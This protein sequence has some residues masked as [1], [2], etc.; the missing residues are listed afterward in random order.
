MTSTKCKYNIYFSSVKKQ[1]YENNSSFDQK[2]QKSSVNFF[3]ALSQS[4]L[5]LLGFCNVQ[6][7]FKLHKTS[8]WNGFD[9]SA[10]YEIIGRFSKI[11][12]FFKNPL[13]VLYCLFL[14]FRNVIF[15]ISILQAHVPMA[16]TS[17]R[18]KK[19]VVSVHV[20]PG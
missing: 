16:P 10:L 19:L 12:K 3:S 9:T 18:V 17:S 6:K 11:S 8:R 15:Q 7:N 1:S 2:M 20:N 5:K 14:Y 13:A 4:S